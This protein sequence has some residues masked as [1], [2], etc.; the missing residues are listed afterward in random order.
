MHNEIL[1]YTSRDMENK[2]VKYK[3]FDAS[4]NHHFFIVFPEFVG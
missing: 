4:R 2:I 3:N 1:N